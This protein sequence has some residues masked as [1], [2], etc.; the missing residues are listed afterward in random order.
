MKQPPPIPEEPGLT[1]PRQRVVATA[2][3]IAF[4]GVVFIKLAP[5][6]EHSASSAA[7][8]NEASCEGVVMSAWKDFRVVVVWGRAMSKASLEWEVR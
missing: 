2:A 1:T 3:S 7:V 6:S 8:T 5:S 4:A